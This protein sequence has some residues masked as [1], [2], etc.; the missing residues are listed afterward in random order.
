MLLIVIEF[1]IVDIQTANFRHIFLCDVSLFR[2]RQSIMK[3]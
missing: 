2:D 1:V 3:F